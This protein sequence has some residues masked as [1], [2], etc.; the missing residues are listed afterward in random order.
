MKPPADSLP[1]EI[2]V[3]DRP[4][5]VEDLSPNLSLLEFLRRNGLTGSKQGCGEG[6]CGACTVI[7]L[8][9]DHNGRP[10]YRAVN[11]CIALLPAFAGR[12]IW[13][14][15]GFAANGGAHPVQEAMVR[16]YGSQCGYCTP[17]FVASLF[18]GYYRPDLKEKWQVCDQLCGNLCRC[19]GYR[20]I[21]DAA[22][23]VLLRDKPEDPFHANLK[24]DAPWVEAAE[25]AAPQGRF[26]R[27]VS[28]EELFAL[29]QKH[30]DAKLVAGATERGVEINKL[31]REYPVLL[32][33]EGVRELHHLEA[34]TDNW[35]IGGACTFT[36]IEEALQGEYPAMDEMIRLFASRQIRNRA[37]MAGN[38]VTASPIGD[39]APVLLALDASVELVSPSAR[40]TVPLSDFFLDYR[41]T[42]LAE[43]EILYSILIPRAVRLAGRNVFWKISKRREMDISIVSGAFR[44]ALDDAGKV[45]EARLVFGGVAAT[46]AR[47]AKAEQALLGTKPAESL[48]AVLAAL[49]ES[50]TPLD[51]VRGSAAFRKAAIAGLWRKFVGGETSHAHDGPADFTNDARWELEDAARDL[52]HE[53]A[54]GHV[55]GAARYVEDTALRR[56]MLETW[57][58]LSPHASARITAIDT[59]AAEAM[60]GV[61]CVLTAKDIPGHN[62]SSHSAHDE[63]LLADGEAAYHGQVVALV[64]GSDI[65]QCRKAAQA[66]KVDYEPREPVLGIEAAMAADS[67]HRPPHRLSRGDAA[68]AMEAAPHRLSGTFFM[69]GQD[70]FYLETHATWAEAGDDGDVFV[71]SSTQHPTEIQ[72]LVAEALGLPRNKVVVEAPRMGGG[73]GGKETQG[74]QWAALAALAATRTGHPVRIQLDRDLDMMITG[75]RHP[76]H[77]TFDVGFDDSGRFLAAKIALVSDGGWSL[78]LSQPVNDR[79]LF[80]LDNAYYIPAVDFTGRIAKTNVTSHTAFRGFGGPQGMLAI[81]EILARVARELKL[82]PEE[83]R[84]RNFYRGTGDTNT[85]HY[86]QEIENNRIETIWEKLLESSDFAAR[87]KAVTQWNAGRTGVKRGLAITPVKFG[88]SFTLKHYNQAGALV[89]V[90]QDGTVQ[91][92]HGGTEMG[93]GLHTKIL[94]VAMRGLGLGAEH[95]RLMHTRTDKV[96]NTSATAA[97]CGSDLNGAAVADACRQLIDRLRPVAASLLAEKSGHPIDAATVVFE[98]NAA[99]AGGA[100]V[101]FGEV[102]MKAYTERISLAAAGF[103][104]TPTLNWSWD[105]GKGR[106]FHYFAFGAAVAEVEVDLCTGMSQVLRVDIL[107]DVGD[108]LNPGIDRGQIEG[109]FVQGMGWLTGEELKWNAEGRLLSH[110]ASTYQI[111]AIGNAPA[112]FRVALLPK[113]TQPRTIGGSKAVGEPPLMLAFS[114][115]E[116]IRDAIAAAVPE[117]AEIPLPSPATPEAI[118]TTYRKAA[119]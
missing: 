116:A 22:C 55:T 56:D 37:T 7:L 26:L 46:P 65:H 57:P 104:R 67:W 4:M 110:S 52:A 73:F 68:R 75:K 114:V 39:S 12:R 38:L 44:V 82:A 103:Y 54:R 76:F 2:T 109:G 27:P 100:E 84:R 105:V 92:N 34:D 93:Q 70:H 32:S 113:A 117:N 3:N 71:A 111:P 78:D 59:S 41:K 15:E 62:N 115:R 40:R 24:G 106:P 102:A 63:P 10:A 83:V 66:V 21:R 35:R 95:I 77:V 86:G 61:A 108:S 17:G 81:E 51:D 1:I 94:G 49:D 58:V 31:F 18:E 6:D 23:E 88:I 9:R 47:A 11:S 36:H 33:V 5:R 53:S 19:T 97:S 90:Y 48:E 118:L 91:V 119:G 87:R 74:N 72:T 112:D 30:P 99:R 20:S 29:R 25:Y 85:T 69:G 43:D 42:V 13:T 80:H 107:H 16:H 50:F 60:P 101:G 28:L 45:S 64:V 79:A 8:D 96:P 98:N 89:L 14:V